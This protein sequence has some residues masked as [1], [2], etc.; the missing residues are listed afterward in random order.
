MITHCHKDHI[1]CLPKLVSKNILRA[2]W[3]LAAD[4]EMGWGS[5]L[6]ESPLDAGQSFEVRTLLAALREEPVVD[7]SD[8]EIARFLL[9]IETL[10]PGYLAMLE[11]LEESGSNVVYYKG[12]DEALDLLEEFRDIGM[13]IL[14]PSREML[15]ICTQ[16]IIGTTSDF[17]SDASSHEFMDANVSEVEMYRRLFSTD[18]VAADASR[19]GAAL[20]C[21]SIVLQFE[22]SDGN[23]LLPGDLQFASPGFGRDTN[24]LTEVKRLRQRISQAGPYDIYKI[25]HHGSD[26]AFESEILTELNGTLNFAISTGTRSYSHPDKGVLELLD[27]HKETL[28]WVRTDRNG[29]CSFYLDHHEVT[30]EI[31]RGE[32]SDP[33]VNVKPRRDI[34]RTTERVVSLPQTEA[35]SVGPSL[36]HRP[37]EPTRQDIEVIA[38]VPHRRTKVTITIDVEPG[39]VDADQAS[40]T[41]QNRGS[42]PASSSSQSSA[43]T[44]GL[45]SLARLP[46]LCFVTDIQGLANNIGTENAQKMITSLQERI[47][48]D[49]QGHSGDPF[50]AARKVRSAL[51][52]NPGVR[53]VVLLGGYDLVPSVRLDVLPVALRRQMPADSRDPDDFVVWSDDVYGDRSG[54]GVAELPISRI[55]DGRSAQLVFAALNSQP[56][57]LV[58]NKIGVRNIRRPFADGVF[59]ILSGNGSMLRSGPTVHTSLPS[60]TSEYIYLML[61]GQSNDATEYHGEGTPGNAAAIHLNNVTSAKSSVVFCGCCWGGL[62]VD[63]P[64]ALVSRNEAINVRTPKDSI[65]LKFLESGANA[66]VGC[67]GAHYSPTVHPYEF[68]GGP[69]HTAFWKR[70]QENYSPAEALF[71]A[72][73]DYI[74]GMFHGQDDV[75][76]QAIEYKT[77]NQFT[78][79]GLGW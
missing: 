17:L 6:D 25:G 33:R 65:A 20:N 30:Y 70:V 77:L 78:C 13:K 55:P 38:R 5:R 3:V 9:D 16:E 74:G 40:L 53:G 28:T 36:S 71:M 2:D 49:V 27:S 51:S 23:I 73:R 69:M 1:G 41:L 50:V 8:E 62:A 48:V 58:N 64:A 67:T 63:T 22:T 15:L 54:D 35:E 68:A 29:R 42:T 12:E 76:G 60:L 37:L 31:Q 7:A 39:E 11:E 4:P 79:L 24:I 45:S 10:R 43:Q 14:G 46:Q 18:E 72:R 19:S 21:M 59:D 56:P 32:A 26:N 47:L 75:V 61:H 44:S 66:F 52:S 34:V 57:R